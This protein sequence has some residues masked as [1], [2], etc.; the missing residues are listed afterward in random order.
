[1]DNT[2]NQATPITA[3]PSN[4][5]RRY[6]YRPGISKKA[7]ERIER[8]LA[9]NARVV[10]THVVKTLN[11]EIFHI[12]SFGDNGQSE[13]VV[14]IRKNPA[15]SCPDFQSRA[16]EEKSYL[17]CKH[18]YFIFLT[19]LGLDQNCNMFVHQPQLSEAELSRALSRE[20]V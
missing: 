20:R 3:N 16:V 12:V 11:H 19:V 1:M 7:L 10:N 13:Y 6:K 4:D 2:T 17:A 14:E 18:I 9:L 15:C 8:S 5:H